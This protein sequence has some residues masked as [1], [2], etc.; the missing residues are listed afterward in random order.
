MTPDP[1]FRPPN[2]SDVLADAARGWLNADNHADF[3]TLSA[4][5]DSLGDLIVSKLSDALQPSLDG[6]KASVDALAQ[7]I[8]SNAVTDADIAAAKDQIDGVKATVDGLANPPADQPPAE[9][10]L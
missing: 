1:V 6:L 4:K 10:P 8:D 9:P 3:L 2:L 5:L 7:R